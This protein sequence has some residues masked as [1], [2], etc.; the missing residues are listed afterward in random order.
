M[1]LK[2]GSKDLPYMLL[3]DNDIISASAPQVLEAFNTNLKTI[4]EI[5]HNYQME[6]VAKRQDLASASNKF[7]Q[8]TLSCS[9]TQQ[10]GR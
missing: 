10:R 1:D 4:R 3:P 8:E 5:S 2:F 9:S 6:L 7:R